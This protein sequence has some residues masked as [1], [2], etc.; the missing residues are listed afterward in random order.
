MVAITQNFKNIKKAL[1]IIQLWLTPTMI[2]YEPPA[3]YTLAN[4]PKAFEYKHEYAYLKTQS[5]KSIFMI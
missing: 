2:C 4:K 3:Q 1:K 5:G